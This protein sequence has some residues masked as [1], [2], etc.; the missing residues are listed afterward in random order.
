MIIEIWEWR[1]W[2]GRR[3]SVCMLF[4]PSTIYIIIYIYTYEHT[5]TSTYKYIKC[6][7]PLVHLVVRRSAHHAF[8][9]FSE[10]RIIKKRE[11]ER[12]RKK[13]KKQ[14]EEEKKNP[15]LGGGANRSV[16]TTIMH[17]PS[18]M[19][20]DLAYSCILMLWFTLKFLK[21]LR[22][23]LTHKIYKRTLTSHTFWHSKDL[24]NPH[25]TSILKV[26]PIELSTIRTGQ[27]VSSR[28]PECSYSKFYQQKTQKYL[29]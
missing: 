19:V 10:D 13:E 15:S 1:W 23:G 17:T 12:E 18:V 16:F 27:T 4:F 14:K 6:P 11:R 28:N 7:Y 24:S 22:I 9:P 2:W 29:K 8:G 21:K 3:W 26:K 20:A 25:L 5:P